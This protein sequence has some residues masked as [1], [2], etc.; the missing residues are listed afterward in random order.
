MSVFLHIFRESK[1]KRLFFSLIF[2]GAF[3]ILSSCTTEPPAKTIAQTD[4][5]ITLDTDNKTTETDLIVDNDVTTEETTDADSGGKLPQK[6]S[7][8]LECKA[9]GDKSA[10]CVVAKCQPG[11]KSDADCKGFPGTKCNV[12]LGRCLNLGASSYAC[13]S[14]KCPSGCCYAVKGF[15]EVKCS[16]TA[17]VTICG[18]CK[19]GEIFLEGKD[20]IPAA[21]STSNDQCPSY[22]KAE[23]DSDCFKCEAGELVCKKD[24]NCNTGTGGVVFTNVVKCI[25]AGQMCVPGQKC[26]SGQPCIQGFCY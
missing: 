5:D 12:A 16:K 15:T 23:S 24:A 22:N 6:C 1:M 3:L 21:C 4:N 7:T 25:S 2:L 13:D 26:C 20:C 18:L 11:C 17:K 9:G 14:K 8:D 10:I 19:Q